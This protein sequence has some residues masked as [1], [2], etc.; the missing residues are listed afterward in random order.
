[1]KKDFLFGPSGRALEKL[2]ALNPWRIRG[3]GASRFSARMK[4]VVPRLRRSSV[5]RLWEAAGDSI[6][7]GSRT[8]AAVAE[9]QLGH[10]WRDLEWAERRCNEVGAE[11]ER[12]YDQARVLDPRLPEPGRV[13]SANWPSRD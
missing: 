3:A 7:V 5:E 11:L 1:M 9:K 2:Y 13:W 6:Q 10:L 4:A 12:L 8:E